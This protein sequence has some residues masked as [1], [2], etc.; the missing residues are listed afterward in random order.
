MKQETKNFAIQLFIAVS[1]V[2]IISTL[3]VVVIIPAIQLS[4]IETELQCNDICWNDASAPIP[5]TGLVSLV[6]IIL[7]MG[8]VL[9]IIQCMGSPID[10]TEK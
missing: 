5:L 7:I 4:M 9:I 10:P 3:L 8:L 1:I 6:G 2:V